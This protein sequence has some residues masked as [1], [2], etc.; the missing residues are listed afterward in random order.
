MRVREVGGGRGLLTDSEYNRQ[1]QAWGAQ[2]TQMA[3]QAAAA[4]TKGKRRATHTYQSGPK[5]GRTERRLKNHIQYGLQSDLGDVAGVS[6]S[7][8]RHGIFLEYGVSRG[9][10]VNAVRRSMS[11][12][13]SGTLKRKEQQLSDIV[14]QYQSDRVLRVFQGF[15]GIGGTTK[16]T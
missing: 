13:L 8:E 3:A 14:T 16:M 9:H 4:H 1:V 2:A 5:R 15:K 12:W 7:F 6:F 11:D 10:G